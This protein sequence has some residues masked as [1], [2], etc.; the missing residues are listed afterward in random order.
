M[1]YCVMAMFRDE[2]WVLNEWIEHYFNEGASQIIL[3][4]NK[5]TDGWYENL[6]PEY[7]TDDRIEIIDYPSDKQGRQVDIYN[8]LLRNKKIKTQWLLCC[9]LDEFLYA[10]KGFKTIQDYLNTVPERVSKLIIPWKTFGSSG[11]DKQPESVRK[12]FTHY[13]PVYYSATGGTKYSKMQMTSAKC[14]ARVSQ[15][16]EIGLHNFLMKTS[17]QWYTNNKHGSITYFLVGLRDISDDA[18]HL[19]HYYT[20]SQEYFDKIQKTRGGGENVKTTKTQLWFD[21]NKDGKIF[22]DELAKKTYD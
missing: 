4:N 6:N 12:G 7:Q 17:G 10:R 20:Q 18:I 9:D 3:I 15:I 11:H 22:D 13:N 19:N 2:S 5:S 8:K 21:K 14:F 1:S 16:R